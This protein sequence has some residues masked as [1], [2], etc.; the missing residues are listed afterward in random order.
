[1]V[2][3]VSPAMRDVYARGLAMGNDPGAFAKVGD[4][5]TESVFFLSPFDGDP[6]LYRLGPYPSLQAVLDNFSGSFGRISIAARTGFGPSAMFDPTW[7]DPR[8][9]DP[10]EGPLACEFRLHRPSIAIIGLGTHYIPENEFESQL[11]AVI[12]YSLDHGVV[13][14]VATKVDVEGGDWVNAMVVYVAQQYQ[15]PVWNFWRSAQPL[16][17]HG[18]PDGIHFTWASN[19]FDSPYSMANGWPVRNL[20]A[21]QALEAVWLAVR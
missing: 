17:N 20:G 13:P 21:L 7:V 3:E 5:N 12:E 15:V 16:Y 4:C 9:C 10:S 14:I 2:P 8:V 18:Q 19:Y 1:V 11:R 6:T